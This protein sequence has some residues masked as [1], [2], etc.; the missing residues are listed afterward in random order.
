MALSSGLACKLR[1]SDDH[2]LSRLEQRNTHNDV[3]DAVLLI[4]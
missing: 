4:R 3:N 1:N 2:E